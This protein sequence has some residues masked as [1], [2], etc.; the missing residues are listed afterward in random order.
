[1]TA[2][3]FKIIKGNHPERFFQERHVTFHNADSQPLARLVVELARADSS[4]IHIVTPGKE[5][6]VLIAWDTVSFRSHQNR[7]GS[8]EIL[9]GSFHSFKIEIASV[10]RQRQSVRIAGLILMPHQA[11]QFLLAAIRQISGQVFLRGRIIRYGYLILETLHISPQI[12]LAPP[13]AM[14]V[15]HRQSPVDTA[16]CIRL[17]MPPVRVG[18]D[19]PS[20]LHPSVSLRVIRLPS[21][22]DAVYF[23]FSLVQPHPMGGVFRKLQTYHAVFRQDNL[24]QLPFHI[25][26][27]IAHPL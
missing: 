9:S 2:V 1:M 16:D 18:D 17:F 14:N 13:G 4:H 24:S 3:E 21:A 23:P 8:P 7:I 19:N 15:H 27:E 12:I 11:Q 25:L 26:A 10:M 5:G 22:Q 6:I 20:F